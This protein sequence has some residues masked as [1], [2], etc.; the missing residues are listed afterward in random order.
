MTE[1]L[2][3]P[4][5]SRFP[6][7]GSEHIRALPAG[8]L[9]GRIHFTGGAYPSAW[10]TFRRFGPTT[11]RFDHHD[12]PRGVHPRRAILYAA[13]TVND[14]DGRTVPV[15]D[16]CLVEVFRDTGVVDVSRNNPYFALF[17][18]QHAVRL[19]DLVDSNWITVAGGN[20]AISSGSRTDSRKWSRA[21]YSTY[22]SV[23]GLYYG[24]SNMPRGRSVALYERAEVALST[25]PELD[26]PL[27]SPGLWG[28][29]EL[30]CS[31]LGL[32]LV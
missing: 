26:L 30:A 7:L 24:C 11:C 25:Y 28:D 12:E 13:P 18:L 31:Q 17:R 1:K 22:E 9:L 6:D 5:V 19:L 21:V 16:V 20:A 14:A 29:V 4:S 23:D 10:N 15:L 2:P 3:A 32:S 8:T 27:S